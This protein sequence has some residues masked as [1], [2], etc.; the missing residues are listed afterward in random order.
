MTCLSIVVPRSIRIPLYLVINDL[1]GH[2]GAALYT[3][4][5]I[6]SYID[7]GTLHWKL[8]L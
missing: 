4:T 3:H 6:S 8:E 1:P 2:S 5:I 7:L